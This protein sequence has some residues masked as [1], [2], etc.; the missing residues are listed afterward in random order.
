MDLYTVLVFIHVLLFVVWLGGDIG[1][2]I[3][4]QHFRRPAYPMDTRLTLLKLLVINDMAPRTAWALMVPVS[5]SMVAMGGYLALPLWG[6]A[7]AW[8]VGALWLWLV[9]TAH[10]HDQTP[11]AARLRV[12][13]FWLK[14]GLTV[15]YLGFGG[16]S[17]ATGDW[18]G[19][20]WLG[21]KAFLFGVIF[22]VAIM[23]DVTFKPLGPALGRLIE[24]GSSDQTES[25][26]LVIMN[27]T[28]RWVLSIYGLL[29]V[30]AFLGNVKPF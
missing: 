30:T 10:L 20:G 4:G 1:V 3:L 17:L 7:L 12:Y 23:I 15:F 25:D 6:L 13:E 29:V 24:E 11:L 2:F 22:A 14:I 27:R 28:R 8:G 18:L 26:V 5:L 19:A 21:G 9:W 16:V